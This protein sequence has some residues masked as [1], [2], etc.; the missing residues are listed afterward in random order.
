MV[1][2]L[3]EPDPLTLLERRYLE[4]CEAGDF[5]TADKLQ[6]EIDAPGDEKELKLSQTDVLV[7]TAIWY[8]TNDIKV[9]PLVPGSKEPMTRSGFKDATT[10]IDHIDHWWRRW[11]AAN[12]GTP[13]GELFD[14]IDVDGPEGLRTWME[15]DL[16]VETIGHV[17]TPRGGGH[18]LYVHPQRR[19][20]K[21]KIGR[22]MGLSGIDYRGDGG[23]V[24]LPPSFIREHGRRYR[25]LK[26]LELPDAH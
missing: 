16:E 21:A 4:A 10:R 6:A 15:L 11:P 26:P 22:K 20:N 24:V 14:V 2:T 23:Y 7:R 5:E 12:I 18:H 1:F 8:A 3:P 17:L 9:F 13:T 19:G 25:W